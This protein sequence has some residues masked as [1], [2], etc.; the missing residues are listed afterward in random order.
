MQT[1]ENI[2]PPSLREPDSPSPRT[3]PLPGSQYYR[4]LHDPKSKKQYYTTF[5]R[6]NAIAAPLYRLGLLPLLG[7]GKLLCC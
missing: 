3:F 2:E 6:F 4:R 1:H 5:K 7:F